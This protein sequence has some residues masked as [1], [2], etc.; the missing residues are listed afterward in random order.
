MRVPQGLALVLC[1]SLGQLA[2]GPGQ[3]GPDPRP[4][5]L[6][7]LSPQLESAIDAALQAVLAS[8]SS[9][10]AW[11]ELAELYHA[12]NLLKDAARC[13]ARALELQPSARG[14]Y[15]LG[16]VQWDL[17]QTEEAAQGWLQ[18][19][20]LEP[21]YAPLYWRLGN[22][23]M[24]AGRLEEARS[25][26]GRA[27]ELAPGDQAASLGLARCQLALGQPQLAAD[28]LEALLERNKRDKRALNLMAR[29]LERLGRS[30]EAER[31]AL[32]EQK[33]QLAPEEDAWL[34]AVLQ[35]KIGALALLA[36]AN[37]L[38]SLG[39]AAQAIEL[40]QAE[41]QRSPDNL[42]VLNMLLGTLVLEQRFEEVL[43]LYGEP[44]SGRREH[45][46]LLVSRGQA[47]MGLGRLPEALQSFQKALELAP[48]YGASHAG[49]G[50][51][52]LRL[53]RNAEAAEALSRATR[54]GQTSVRDWLILGQAELRAERFEAALEHAQ[55]ALSLHPQV[56]DL[57]ALGA[58]AALAAKRR[59][60]ALGWIEMLAERRPKHPKLGALQE[61]L[62]AL[63]ME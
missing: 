26:F 39:Q 51:A 9:S 56:P 27:L 45:H 42:G 53:G 11:L 47:L 62:R 19:R 46:L 20:G 4:G 43:A 3:G 6:S 37:Q 31:L 22:Y 60:A 21:G 18:A 17:G 1:L 14:L 40:L 15:L 58:E 34:S 38:T 54:L 29:V 25:L 24:Q 5:A 12:N 2:C 32:R 52:L 36:E 35:R 23:Q 44:G 61:R 57:W 63:P 10:Q 55:E 28:L 7:E 49:M 13:Y 41:L 50:E 30:Q 48:A 33:A 16:M 59:E 8:R